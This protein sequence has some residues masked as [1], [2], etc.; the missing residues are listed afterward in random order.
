MNNRDTH[1]LGPTLRRALSG[2]NHAWNDFFREIRK[3]LHAEVRKLVGPHA[4]GPLEHSVL[5]QSTLRRAWERIGEQFPDGPEDAALRRFLA[6]VRTIVRNRTCEDLRRLRSRPVAAGS[7]IDR[8]AEP[9]PWERAQRRDHLAAALAVE[10][11]RLPDRQRQVIE[12]F[13]F[14][15]LSDA[16]IGQRVGCS[17]G[18]VR[19]LRFRALR[20]LRS[21]HLQ[22][23]LEQSHDDR[24]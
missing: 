12:L 17:P 15:L 10:L 18:A 16:E 4:Q 14:E 3:Y 6:W 2:D 21:A 1:H 8:I 23:L 22:S 24:C 19:V 11:G 5:V 7:D 9:R 13:W 20:S